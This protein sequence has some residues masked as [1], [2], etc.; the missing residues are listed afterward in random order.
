MGTPTVAA[1]T[2]GMTSPHTWPA[3]RIGDS[4]RDRATDV[5]T[6]A[7]VEGRLGK[8][9]FDDRLGLVLAA[10]NRAD[11]D[12]A[13]QGLA[14]PRPAVALPRPV[15]AQ[16]TGLAAVAHFSVFV[17][18][19]IGPLLC[20]AVAAPGS[21]ARREA[22]KAFNW[23]VVATIATVVLNVVAGVLLPDAL[24]DRVAG[25]AWVAW[26]VLTIMG[27]VHAARGGSWTNPMTRLVPWNVLDPGR[28]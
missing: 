2:G 1:Q 24:A 22:A 26:F 18:W 3:L 7:Y 14:L 5:L 10:T 12:G 16:G 17:S 27:G 25:I 21:Y 28:R 23:Q 11:L 9:E 15:V 13:F 19:I 8:D 20:W 6:Q 4:D